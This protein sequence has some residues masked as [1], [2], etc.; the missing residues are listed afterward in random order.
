M[1]KIILTLLALCLLVFTACSNVEVQ[2]DEVI[3]EKLLP[4]HGTYTFAGD[5]NKVVVDENGIKYGEELVKILNISDENVVTT[6][7]KDVL[8]RFGTKSVMTNI[9]AYE[10]T[11]YEWV[12]VIET[13]DLKIEDFKAFDGEYTEEFEYSID[14][15]KNENMDIGKL[16]INED[17]TFSLEIELK[18]Q[19][20]GA[21]HLDSNTTHSQAIPKGTYDAEWDLADIRVGEY[22]LSYEIDFSIS[23]GTDMISLI[24]GVLYDGLAIG[25]YALIKWKE[26]VNSEKWFTPIIGDFYSGEYK[27]TIFENGEIEYSRKDNTYK[28]VLNDEQPKHVDT[29]VEVKD[30]NDDTYYL[31]LILALNADFIH[32]EILELEDDKYNYLGGDSLSR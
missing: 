6:D 32:T 30:D 25:E 20:G 9:A 26:P 27:L 22:G 13:S 12:Y 23:E 24:P 2:S 3:A 19:Y 10:D 8:L 16:V 5:Q 4:F 15:E 29:M 31:N 1:K 14:R 7:N 28:G 11:D 18:E 17:G 21:S